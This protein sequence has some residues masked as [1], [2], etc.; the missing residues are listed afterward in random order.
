MRSDGAIKTDIYKYLKGSALMDEVTGTLRKTKR[1]HNSTKEDVIISIL[2]NVGV[3]SQTATVN[4]NIY[5][6]DYDVDGQYEENT[7]RIEE[8]STMAWLTLESFHT[9]EY[10]ANAVNQRVYETES[11]EHVINTQIEYKLIND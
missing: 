7:S 5:V 6:Q 3:Q 11:G 2:A 8:L 10:K 1:P 9:D 4:V